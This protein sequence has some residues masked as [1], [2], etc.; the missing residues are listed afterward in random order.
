MHRIDVGRLQE[1]EQLNEIYRAARGLSLG[2]GLALSEVLGTDP[3]QA[4]ELVGR[5]QARRSWPRG[6]RPHGVLVLVADHLD[7][8]T[9]IA[10]SGAG[11]TVQGPISVF[12]PG[13]G[14]QRS[15][16]FVVAVLIASPDGHTSPLP[17]EAYVHPCWSAA[18]LLPVDSTHERRCLD[19]LVR[20]QGWMAAQGYA[21]EITKPFYDRS[22]YYVGQEAADLV[23]KPDFEGVIRSDAGAFVRSFVVEV[24]GYD[25]GEYRVRKDRLKKVVLDKRVGYIEHL[26]HDEAASTRND[27]KLVLDLAEFGKRSIESFKTKPS[28]PPAVAPVLTPPQPVPERVKAPF[29]TP[30]AETR[31]MAPDPPNLPS[32]APSPR[33]VSSPEPHTAEPDE[34]SRRISRPRI[35]TRILRLFR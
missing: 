9:I 8:G 12:G 10:T 1:K 19:I 35:F 17:L 33:L 24:M 16:P 23:V 25:H 7:G 15:G 34:G 5:L 27:R 26:A 22:R 4:I 20:F 13:K 3:G 21:V 30:R 14:S 18:D 28:G 31:A 29:V 2:K 32:A 6:R 11:I